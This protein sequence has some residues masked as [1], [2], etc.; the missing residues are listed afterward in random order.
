S[1]GAQS[2][3]VS[4]KLDEI[5]DF[6][7]KAAPRSINDAQKQDFLKAAGTNDKGSVRL[8]LVGSD[9]ESFAYSRQIGALLTAGGW[10]IEYRQGTVVN[11]DP[12]GIRISVLDA[13][14]PSAVLLQQALKLIGIDAAGTIEPQQ[15]VP[16]V[17]QVGP[18]PLAQ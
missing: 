1:K 11:G 3:D 15:E 17:L 13:K 4:R 7:H 14:N 12:S 9:L 18:K 5:L 8:L 16:I 2:A 6:I 10:Q